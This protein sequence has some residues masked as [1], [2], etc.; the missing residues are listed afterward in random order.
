MTVPGL[1]RRAPTP[2]EDSQ[3]KT[4]S[5]N[6]FE[7]SEGQANQP[8]STDTERAEIAS[9]PST[10]VSLLVVYPALLAWKG[11]EVAGYRCCSLRAIC[12]AGVQGRK[13]GPLENTLVETFR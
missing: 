6:Q 11:A 3:I 7:A 5:T 8:T 12:D 1:Q 2:E 13:L 9:H 10:K 4:A